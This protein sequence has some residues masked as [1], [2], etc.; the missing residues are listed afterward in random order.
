MGGLAFADK[1]DRGA[2]DEVT[3]DLLPRKM[4]LVRLGPHVAACAGEGVGLGRGII[5]GGA[6]RF[7]IADVLVVIEHA[8][9]GE[10]GVSLGKREEKE[11]RKYHK[12]FL[13][14]G[15]WYRV[16]R[17]KISIGFHRVG[18]L[19]GKVCYSIQLFFTIQAWAV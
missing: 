6:L 5:G 1:L 15:F 2:H 14:S 18:N 7:W 11:Y 19:V 13:V 16:E 4:E 3:L 9:G 10:L 8:E 17:V 12:P